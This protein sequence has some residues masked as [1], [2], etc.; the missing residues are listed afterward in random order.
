MLKKL[1]ADAE[2]RLEEK[3]GRAVITRAV[4]YFNDAQRQAT[5]RAGELAG[6]KVERI[7]N[8]PTAAALALRPRPAPRKVAG[9]GV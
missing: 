6:L 9:G 3:I 5:S 2:F 8:E 7:L 1:R 4:A